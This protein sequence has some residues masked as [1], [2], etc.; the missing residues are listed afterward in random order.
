MVSVC[1]TSTRSW[2]RGPGPGAGLARSSL[3]C[4]MT[5]AG[6]D[7]VPWHTSSFRACHDER[8]G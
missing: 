2:R 6:E 4:L 3:T 1:R 5:M 8:E 7:E